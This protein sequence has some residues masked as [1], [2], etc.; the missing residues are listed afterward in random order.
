M[1][2][3]QGW[4]SAAREGDSRGFDRIDA[5]VRLPLVDMVIPALRELSPP[6]YAVFKA[7]VAEL[8]RADR[9]TDLFEWTLQRVLLHHLSPGFERVRAPRASSGYIT[10]P[11]FAG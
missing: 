11:R 10:R 2:Q 8:I 5:G 9:K 3:L 1:E 4:I 7:N 6:Q